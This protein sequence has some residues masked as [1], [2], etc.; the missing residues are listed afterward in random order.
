[1]LWGKST[2]WLLVAV[3]TTALLV[4]GAPCTTLRAVATAPTAKSQQVLLTTMQAEQHLMAAQQALAANSPVS[5]ARSIYEAAKLGHPHGQWLMGQALRLGKGVAPNPAYARYW[6]EAASQQDDPRALWNLGVAKAEGYGGLQSED[7]ALPLFMRSAK[8]GSTKAQWV[9]A[10]WALVGK[11]LGGQANVAL[12]HTH[13]KS[14]AA[15]PQYPQAKANV[16]WLMV[17]P[18]SKAYAPK[19]GVLWLRQ[20]AS[21]GLVLAQY[22]AGL[23]ALQGC[24]TMPPSPGLGQQ[25][26]RQAAGA[27]YG[28][29]QWK[30]G[31]VLLSQRPAEA[32]FWINQASQNKV[33]AAQQFVAQRW[34]LLPPA[35]LRSYQSQWPKLTL[36]V[37]HGPS[38]EYYAEAPLVWDDSFL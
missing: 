4:L 32:W 28:P 20:A 10:S 15:L 13:W 26:L 7:D 14:L 9:V 35:T 2:R 22:H 29:A 36:P 1:M 23:N 34:F 5:A 11:G 3:G 17:Q 27:G 16:A 37:W 19:Q 6:Y 18:A 21:Q 38:L 30:L 24:S 25:Y 8:A 33:P 12:A 31:Q